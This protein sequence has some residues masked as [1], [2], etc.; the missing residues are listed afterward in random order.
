MTILK[1][2]IYAQKSTNASSNRILAKALRWE[3]LRRHYPMRAHIYRTFNF[4]FL[5]DKASYKK[6]V[7]QNIDVFLNVESFSRNFYCALQTSINYNRPSRIF[8]AMEYFGYSKRNI[9]FRRRIPL[10]TPHKGDIRN[11]KTND[12][13][14]NAFIPGCVTRSS[15]NYLGVFVKRRSVG[16]PQRRDPRIKTETEMKSIFPMGML[17]T[18]VVPTLTGYRGTICAIHGGHQWNALRWSRDYS[19]T[20]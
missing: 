3:P 5:E 4:N 16:V 1:L 17:G 12:I 9:V 2:P 11:P 10:W 19:W 18:R 6:N 13:T 20:S 7:P 14:R 8:F 15:G